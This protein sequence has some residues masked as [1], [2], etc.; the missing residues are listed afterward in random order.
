M[1]VGMISTRYA[2][3][4]Y[5]YAKEQKQ[6]DE[7]YSEM[8][9]LAVAFAHV[10]QLR[11]T[12]NNPTLAKK[13][14]ESLLNAA[15]GNTMN[16]LYVRFIK[17]VL[18][19]RREEYLQMMALSYGDIYCEDKQINTGLLITATQHVG[20][21]VKSR[22]RM[23]LNK[24]KQGTLELET[25]VDPEIEG[26]FMLYIDTFRLDAS[27]KTQLKRIKENLVAEN[28]RRG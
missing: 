12:M 5:A 13:E 25:K 8:K 22:I 20:E 26:G 6:E 10:S 21:G 27:V 15:V 1:N 14:K 28:S 19:H 3:A 7:V 24:V 16:A 9:K 18:E 17:L 4:L 11:T 23:L 2:K